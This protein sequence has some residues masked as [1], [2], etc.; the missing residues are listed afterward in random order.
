VL[1]L[2]IEQ[3]KRQRNRYVRCRYLGDV[4]P[5]DDAGF[6][7]YARSLPT[8]EICNVLRDRDGHKPF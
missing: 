5:A 2:R 6:I 1:T 3:G 8:P 4:A 7:E